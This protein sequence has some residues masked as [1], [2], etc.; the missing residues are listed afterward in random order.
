MMAQRNASKDL[1]PKGSSTRPGR[2]G[3][4]SALS[5]EDVT[6]MTAVEAVVL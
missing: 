5:R 3:R 6:D 4:G 2:E 1:A